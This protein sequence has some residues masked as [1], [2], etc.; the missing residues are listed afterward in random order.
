[1]LSRTIDFFIAGVQKGG[2]TALDH[3]LRQ[4]SRI[5]MA[6]VKEAHH[7]DDEARI[8][9]SN[10]HHDG[11]HGLFD[12]SVPGVIRGE[13]TPIY[14]YWPRSLERIAQYNPRAKLVVALRHPT[15]RAFSHW[16]M[17]A[18]RG[19]DTLSFEDAIADRGRQRVREAPEGSHRVF[20]YIERG[21]YREQIRRIFELYP[22]S[23]VHF[24]RTDDLWNSTAE[25]LGHIERF[26][27]L[28]AQLGQRAKQDYVVPIETL[29]L[30][31]M[32]APV[33][34]ALDDI[35]REYIGDTAAL[36]GLDLSDWLHLEYAEPMRRS[37]GAERASEL[38]LRRRAGISALICRDTD[39]GK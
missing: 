2:T 26:L 25:T 1:M 19:Y 21:F 18:K 33:R 22:R 39:P 24:F 12:W 5:Q 17:E 11:L 13:S 27:Q 32:S 35:F 14:S 8:D 10:P 37:D 6:S 9:W 23:Q 16:R 31:Q 34:C 29:S 28:E 7:F 38:D 4:H 30:G 36:T 20:S 3:Y 15:F